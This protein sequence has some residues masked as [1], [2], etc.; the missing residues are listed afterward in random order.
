MGWRLGHRF[1]LPGAQ[2]LLGF[3]AFGASWR[4]AGPFAA[5]IAVA[6]W[7]L[8]CTVVAVATFR[9]DRATV[10]RRVLRARAYRET[11][12]DWLSSGSGFA[13]GPVLTAH[14]REL[15]I[16]LALATAS[17]NLLALLA[18]AILLNSMNAW[19]ATLLDAA[20][21]PLRVWLLAW[22]AWSVARVAAYILLGAAA[23]DLVAGLAGLPGDPAQL[24]VLWIAGAA[25]IV[26]DVLL[27]LTLSGACGRSLAGAVDL[28]EAAL[29]GGSPGSV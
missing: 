13:A 20:R 29:R 17:G 24:R 12:Q 18:G 1:A 5:V 8:G 3:V 9:D 16:Y 28:D 25:G 10:D 6:G 23:A 26:L 7:A 19:V 27:K 14:L 21:R 15:A 11:M 22:P 4:A 2:A